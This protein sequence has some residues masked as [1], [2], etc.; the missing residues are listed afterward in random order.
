MLVS[1]LWFVVDYYWFHV[2][3]FRGW[4]IGFLVVIIAIESVE[5]RMMTLK[6]RVN[7]NNMR[8]KRNNIEKGFKKG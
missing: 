3:D 7:S 6:N 4:F 2:V 5:V 8:N 1:A